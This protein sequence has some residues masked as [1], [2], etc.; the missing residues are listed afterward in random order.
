MLKKYHC[1]SDTLWQRHNL[2]ALFSTG[3]FD[4]SRDRRPMTNIHIL[5]GGYI[6][7]VKRFFFYKQKGR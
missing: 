4:S 6:Y 3:F 5:V 1:F 7:K 2:Q